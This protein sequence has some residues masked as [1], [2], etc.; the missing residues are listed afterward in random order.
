MRIKGDIMDIIDF[1][2]HP[3]IDES[4]NICQHKEYF[5][6]TPD[7]TVSYLKNM[8][9]NKI[10]GSVIAKWND[11]IGFQN[12]IE[13]NNTALKLK[14]LYG[15]FYVPGMVL[16][17][18]YVKESLE[19]I[20][21]MH[22]HGV[23]LIGELVP[24]HL[25][26]WSNYNTKE[27]SEIFDLAAQ[28]EMVVNIHNCD[29]EDMEAAVKNNKNVNFVIAHPGEYPVYMHHLERMKKYENYHLDLSGTGLFR[30]GMLRRG[31][32]ECGVERFLFGTDYPVCNPGMYVGGILND[33]LITDS[34]KEAVLSKNAKRLLKL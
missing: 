31:I 6:Q 14:E 26:T 33:S 13:S 15:D 25:G 28:Y 1:H 7:D 17:P 4:T 3:F 11:D 19:E 16:S 2:T 5:E 30:H 29:T 12:I 32:N 9:I 23:K 18:E 8:G 34:E 27:F 20:E 22:S 10:C 24:R 21:R